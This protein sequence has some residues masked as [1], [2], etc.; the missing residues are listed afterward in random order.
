M[1]KIIVSFFIILV[2]GCAPV[3]KDRVTD[4]GSGEITAEHFWDISNLMI[5]DLSAL[6]DNAPVMTTSSSIRESN[7]VI[8]LKNTSS[9]SL[10]ITGLKISEPTNGFSI[11]LNRCGSVILSNKSCQVT[12]SF[13]S[14]DI[15]DGTYN[16]T[17]EVNGGFLQLSGSVSDKPNP[18]NASPEVTLSLNSGFDPIGN[19]PHRTLTITN[20]GQGNANN[21][22]LLIPEEY[23]IQLNRCPTILKP[24]SFCTMQ[25]LYKKAKLPIPETPTGNI[26]VDAS[27]LEEPVTLDVGSGIQIP[28]P[29]SVMTKKISISGGSVCAVSLTNDLKCWGSN[30]NTK[31]GIPNVNSSTPVFVLNQ[32]IKDLDV[33]GNYSCFTNA[34]RNMFC[35]GTSANGNF[36]DGNPNY[37]LSSFTQLNVSDIKGIKSGKVNCIISGNNNEVFCTGSGPVGNGTSS[38]LTFV[39]T[40]VSNAVKIIG[41]ET[42]CALLAD[43]TIKCWGYATNNIQGLLWN[44]GN[45][46]QTTPVS[47]PSLA[48]I[49]DIEIAPLGDYMCKIQSGVLSCAGWNGNGQL[50]NGTQTQS[51]NAFV[52]T[53]ITNAKKVYLGR[54]NAT[55]CAILK[56]KT[57]K[58]WGNNSGGILG[59][60]SAVA[61]ILSPTTVLGLTDVVDMQIGNNSVAC[62]LTGSNKLFCWGA[63]YGSTPVEVML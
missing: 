43:K 49:S 5:G 31:L 36:G 18:L 8:I 19:I 16:N 44:T 37:V 59:V 41:E 57:V 10:P 15:Y 13:K 17:L 22:V 24:T 61:R 2:Q 45:L 52:E 4:D 53:G 60:G 55:T 25:V 7:L 9:N 50:G 63:S 21:V 62:A 14:K 27:N 26:Q 39:N 56:D 32:D 46:T 54:T 51:N 48:G 28:T 1:N 58:C 38:S 40:G 42:V 11:K 3:P 30:N 20:I 12:V 23:I 34:S 6:P 33:G 35:S 47:I 29:L